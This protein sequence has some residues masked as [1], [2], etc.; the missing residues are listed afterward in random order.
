[1]LFTIGCEDD[2]TTTGPTVSEIVLSILG[3]EDLGADARYEGWIMV[4]GSP[5]TTGKFMVD[6][7]GALD[8]TTFSVDQDDLSMATAFILT[9]EPHPDPNPDPSDVHIIAGDF[10]GNSA[11][12]DIMHAAAL[13]DDFSSASG[14]Y[15][16]AT[17]T[18]A[19]T[20][21]ELSGIW[22]L[23]PTSGP[24]VAGLD[25][26]I[27]PAGWIYEGWTVID[28][29]PVTTGKFTAVDA[30]DNSAPYSST[31]PAPPFPGEDF[32]ENAPAGLLFPTDISGGTAVISVEPDPD[33]SDDPFL[34]KPL[35]GSIPNP[36][37]DH[38]L[39][40]MSLNAPSFPTGTA[41]R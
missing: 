32:L 6:A 12:L 13:G 29:V 14:A 33:N 8:E 18:S 31:M 15:I 36:A 35:V 40:A 20:T 21:D 38:T 23:D 1:M 2:D 4:N 30:A 25:L 34:L 16:L 39:Y 27:L 19:D 28:G 11:T 7:N 5:V 24:P 10:S 26:P 22:F 17:P 9:I 37:I 3:L 41:T